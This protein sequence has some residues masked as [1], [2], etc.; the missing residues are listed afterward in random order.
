ML[1]IGLA[2]PAIQIQTPLITRFGR[3]I[4][5]NWGIS[6]ERYRYLEYPKSIYIRVVIQHTFY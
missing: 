1:R 5:G 4:F 3:C 2:T 6:F